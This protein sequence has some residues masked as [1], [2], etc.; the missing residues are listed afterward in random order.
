MSELWA[1]S[2]ERLEAIEAASVGF[3][4]D[5]ARYEAFIERTSSRGETQLLIRDGVARIPVIGPLLKVPD[6]FLDVFEGG[7]TLYGD[8]IQAVRMADVDPDVERIVLEIDSPGGNLA[9]LFE[10]T[11]AIR[12]VTK[13]VEA[14]VTDTALSAAFAIAVSADKVTV[15]NP[16]ALT[17][18]VGI[19]TRQLIDSD[20]V[21]ITSTEA[22][23][24]DPDV[25]TAAG[26]A[27]IRETLDAMHVEFAGIIARGRGVTVDTVNQE[28]GR[29]ASVIAE[30]ALQ[31]GMIDAIGGS[32]D[33][34]QVTGGPTDMA[35]LTLD[36]LRAQHPEAYAAAVQ[37]GVDRER[38]R[39]TAH[40][41]AG[42]SYGAG[43]LAARNILDGTEFT[44]QAVQAGYMAAGQTAEQVAA[45]TADDESAQTSNAQTEAPD[46]DAETNAMF[47]TL[48]S[49]AGIT[50]GGIS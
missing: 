43:E 2:R 37:A 13:P 3:A 5:Q 15:N 1:I 45:R 24:K 49:N 44:S 17:G 18:S 34:S 21:T 11:E 33:P 4:F 42:A 39:V 31:A 19:V 41:T 25:A 27:K 26:I 22:P 30:V 47:D 38:D 28:F 14:Q 12:R 8:I 32:E 40:V 36:E 29:G 46:A 16:L 23:D 7:S 6:F 10:A 48:E 50:S 20:R 35:A 9:G